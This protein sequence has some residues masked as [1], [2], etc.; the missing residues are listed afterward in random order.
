MLRQPRLKL[1]DGRTYRGFCGNQDTELS[2]VARS[3]KKHHHRPCH[4]KSEFAAMILFHQ[5][6]AQVD[7]RSCPRRS[8]DITVASP[9]RIGIDFDLGKTDGQ[10]LRE[11]PVSRSPPPIEKARPS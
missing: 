6:Q 10:F 11:F 2:L 8:V 9:A 3:V 7:S 5:G 1:P 4:I